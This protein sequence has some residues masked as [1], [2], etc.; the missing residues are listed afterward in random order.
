MSPSEAIL[1]GLARENG[2]STAVMIPRAIIV[3]VALL[4]PV[5]HPVGL[6][7]QIGDNPAWIPETSA[8]RPCGCVHFLLRTNH[9]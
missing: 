1:S 5:R 9:L 3:F 8:T 4:A 2:A 6:V 7:V